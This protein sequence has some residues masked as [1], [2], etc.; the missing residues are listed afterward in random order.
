MV[1]ASLLIH[2]LLIKIHSPDTPT[3]ERRKAEDSLKSLSQFTV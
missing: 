1:E 3:A 2:D